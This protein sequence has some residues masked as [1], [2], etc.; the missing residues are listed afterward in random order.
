MGILDCD[1]EIVDYF[2]DKMLNFLYN[3]S[4]YGFDWFKPLMKSGYEVLFLNIDSITDQSNQFLACYC[5]YDLRKI[6]IKVFDCK[7]QAGIGFTEI[8]NEYDELISIKNIID[9]NG[10]ETCTSDTI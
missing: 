6:V 4:T 2:K 5:D 7:G 1:F 10:F 9:G 8:I 3:H